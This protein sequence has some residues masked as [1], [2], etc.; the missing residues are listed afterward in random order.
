MLSLG[1]CH[2]FCSV[3]LRF[4]A[5]LSGTPFLSSLTLAVAVCS[6]FLN[7]GE[8]QLSLLSRL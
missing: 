4:L 3:H 5:C 8:G 1:S 6:M 2:A 7:G